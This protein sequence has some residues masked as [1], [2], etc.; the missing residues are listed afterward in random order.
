[1]SAAAI[2]QA[3]IACINAHDADAIAAA[4][5]PDHVFIDSLGTR[6]TGRETMRE[7]WRAYLRMVPDYCLIVT[8]VFSDGADVVVTGEAR[9][10][11]SADGSL[12]ATNAWVTPAAC[13][14]RVEA[15]LIAEWQVYADNEP[16]RRC[17]RQA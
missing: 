7:G 1:M 17:M 10:T 12:Q 14:A 4:L 13:R 9:G 16:L 5:T 3:F 2:V 6:V 11:W 15:G 8:R